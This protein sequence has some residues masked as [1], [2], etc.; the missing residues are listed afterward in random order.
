MCQ[1]DRVDVTVNSGEHGRHTTIG[2]P[3]NKDIQKPRKGE[4]HFLPEY[5]EGMDDHN[6]DGAHQ[7]L[8]S[9][10]MKTKPNGS[11]IKKDMDVAFAFWR[12]E[13]QLFSQKAR[14]V[15]LFEYLQKK[16]MAL[17]VLNVMLN[18][19][20]HGL[21]C[22]MFQ[23]CYEFNRVVGKILREN[24]FD[25]L[26]HFSPN[27]TDLFRKK[28]GWAF[29]VGQRW[30]DVSTSVYSLFISV[31]LLS[32]CLSYFLL[33]F[34]LHSLISSFPHL[35][36]SLLCS[37]LF[38]SLLFDPSPFCPLPFLSPFLSCHL[39]SRNLRSWKFAVNS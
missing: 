4:I 3:P 6:L 24:I 32:L 10:I 34:P 22:L 20:V 19:I 8:V 38:S 25:A 21:L 17:Y 2:D 11:L 31:S 7:V 14:F 27:L 18:K 29:Y 26:I 35:L 39:F 16:D 37:S 30:V 9:E 15:W 13:V 33:S 23:V 5:P 1:L 28:K 12:K 36:F